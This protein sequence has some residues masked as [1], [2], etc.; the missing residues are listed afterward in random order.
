[1]REVLFGVTYD[2]DSAELLAQ[3]PPMLVCDGAILVIDAL[4]KTSGGQVFIH[5]RCC[6]AEHYMSGAS[7]DDAEWSESIRPVVT[8]ADCRYVSSM[9]GCASGANHSSAKRIKSAA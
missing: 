1:M 9:L 2:T 7:E 5:T 6:L 4:L 8:D 3:S